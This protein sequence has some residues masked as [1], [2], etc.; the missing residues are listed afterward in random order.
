[1]S[2][3]YLN[4]FGVTCFDDDDDDDDDVDDV[5]IATV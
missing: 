5:M 3:A 4:L 1:M 2:C